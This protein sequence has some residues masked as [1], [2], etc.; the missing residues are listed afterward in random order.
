MAVNTSLDPFFSP[1]SIAHIGASERG[2]YPAEIFKN[3][4]E[5]EGTLY[6]VN[7]GRSEIFSVPAYPSVSELPEVPD[8]ALITVQRD[9]VLPLVDECARLG[10]KGLVIISAGF[11]EADEHGRE[12]QRQ[13]SS[14]SDRI[15]IIGPNCAGLASVSDGFILTRLFAAPRKGG[16]CFL[17]SSGALMMAL[18]GSFAGRGI[19]LRRMASLGNQADVSMEEVMDYYLD[20]PDVSAVTAFIEGIGSGERFVAAL[21]K[22]ASKKTP[23]ICIKSGKSDIGS[24]VA[25]THTASLASS[26]KVFESVCRQYGAILAE[27]TD[28]MLDIALMADAVG[29]AS[30]GRIGVLSQSGGA[31]SLLAD[32]I[33][34]HPELTLP[35]LPEGCDRR[36]HELSGI[37]SYARL[38]NPLD[39]RGDTMRGREIAATIGAMIEGNDWDL[40][41][42][43]FAKNPNR[44]VELETAR[45]I[46]EASESGSTPI[47]VVWIGEGDG[48]TG[49]SEAFTLLKNGGIPL[50]TDPKA[51]VDAY[52]ALR[53]QGRLWKEMEEL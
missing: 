22:A 7:P 15:R 46:L 40:L 29:S 1:S 32:L 49:A 24:R 9:R 36:L 47:A 38:L 23:V 26:G 31:A 35:E 6:P 34:C 45:G 5:W 11:A 41:I 16:V 21:K 44:D 39:A 19:G 43:A 8:I 14:Y 10:V 13:L 20:D 4:M 52:A 17:S 28:Q 37:P 12:L 30:G 51:L 42:L 50:F 2:I 53:K 33:S 3:L 27:S 18:F 25:A 48:G